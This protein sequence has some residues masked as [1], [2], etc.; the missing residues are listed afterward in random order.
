MSENR[1][2]VFVTTPFYKPLQ[3]TGFE[4]GSTL[5][6]TFEDNPEIIIRLNPGS[7][8]DFEQALRSRTE[9]ES[10]KNYGVHIPKF[11]VVQ[12]E[13]LHG[14]EIYT[15]TQR[16]HGEKLRQ[17]LTHSNPQLLTQFENLS[18]G[19]LH[20][21]QDRAKPG[22]PFLRDI[23]GIQQY[24]YGTLANNKI[25]E[26]YLV[27]FELD[28]TQFTGKQLWV[29][30]WLDWVSTIAR[31]IH[32]GE[33]LSGQRLETA[34][35]ELRKFLKTLPRENMYIQGSKMIK[36]IL[37]GREIESEEWEERIYS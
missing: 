29:E 22:T 15:V 8:I 5:K 14:E 34:S 26:I 3:D 7:D 32:K 24:M 17:A 30:A 12:G 6:Y 11:D 16:V 28:L 27:D 35:K 13:K 2:E 10:L 9:Y 25:P 18:L 37:G 23:Y 21:L 1:N 31:E 33:N 19:L 4:G 20:Y 36:E